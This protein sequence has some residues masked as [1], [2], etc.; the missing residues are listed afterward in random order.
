MEDVDN[1]ECILEEEDGRIELLALLS[2]CGGRQ[3]RSVVHSLMNTVMVK[4]LAVQFT[5]HGKGGKKIL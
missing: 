5:L 2:T 4:E 3:L 1:L